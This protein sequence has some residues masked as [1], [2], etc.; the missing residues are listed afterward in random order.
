MAT[1][2]FNHIDFIQK[3]VSFSPR[4]YTGEIKTAD[5]LE[6]Y[7]EKRKIDFSIQKFKTKVPVEKKAILKADDKNIPCKSTCFVSGKIP[8][9]ENLI[10]SLCKDFQYDEQ[11]GYNINFNPSCKSISCA[12]FYNYPAV[13][14]AGKD[15]NKI[16]NAKKV[17]GF[18]EIEPTTYT[19]RNILVGNKTNPKIICFAHYDSVLTG[20]WDNASGVSTIMAS[21]IQYPE[22]LKSILYVFIANEEMSYDKEPVYWCKGFRAFEERNLALIEKSKR[23]IVV[24]GVG[25]SPSYWMDKYENLKS[26]IFFRQLKKFMP[27]IRRLGASTSKFAQYIYHSEQDTIKQIKKKHLI[28]TCQEL[29][30]EISKIE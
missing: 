22:T 15:I 20:A 26:T 19:A 12:C 11:L 17:E 3:I 5:F 30:K 21:I 1:P 7:L 25:I 16:L 24:D 14:V 4:Q 27:K 28:Q 18:V 9:K 13:A 29:H 2:K 6:N 10:S 8:N 23:I